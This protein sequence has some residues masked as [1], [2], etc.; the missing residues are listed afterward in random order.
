MMTDKHKVE[1]VK[2]AL[3]HRGDKQ[4]EKMIPSRAIVS[5]QIRH[6]TAKL[7]NKVSHLLDDRERRVTGGWSHAGDSSRESQSSRDHSLTNS[8]GGDYQ[9]SESFKFK[10]EKW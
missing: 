4:Q 3:E 6:L 1:L 9:G 7:S 2:K 5:I 10:C 8:A